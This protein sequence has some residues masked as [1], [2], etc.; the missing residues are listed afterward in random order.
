MLP[1]LGRVSST[2]FLDLLTLPR[3][4]GEL[5]YQAVFLRNSGSF[6]HASL[7]TGTK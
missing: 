3:L 2:V 1:F 7:V 6:W 5:I 4:F